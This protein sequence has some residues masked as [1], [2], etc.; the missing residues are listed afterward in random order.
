MTSPDPSVTGM[1]VAAGQPPVSQ[2]RSRL[3]LI[4]IM[5]IFVLPVVIAYAGFFGGWFRD[6]GSANKGELV[7]GELNVAAFGLADAQGAALP[8]GW[9]ESKWWLV[10][11]HDQPSCDA[12]CQRAVITVRQTWLA[13][14]KHQD[15]I[16]P[17]MAA[18]AVA[19][20]RL[21]ELPEPVRLLRAPV[22]DGAWTGQGASLPA[23]GIYIIDP[24][25]TV[26]L[27]YVA[28]KTEQDA[29][30]RAKDIGKDVKTL[31][32]FSRIG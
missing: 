30:D 21:M 5:L 27:R 6:V 1:P 4:G 24:I 13:T 11:V 18:P 3:T 20:A 9:Q 17:A 32:R 25:G 26:V 29:I 23:P 12:D 8:A 16:V 7:A 19:D 2:L 31:M 14:G 28:P 15:R 10:Y 22:A